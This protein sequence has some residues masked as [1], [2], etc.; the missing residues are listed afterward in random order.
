MLDCLCEDLEVID[1]RLERLADAVQHVHYLV[2]ELVGQ[3]VS[4]RPVVV[5]EFDV[6]DVRGAAA[7]ACAAATAARAASA[8]AT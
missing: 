1:E 2:V 3:P 8:G 4:E 6:G 7:T 5:I